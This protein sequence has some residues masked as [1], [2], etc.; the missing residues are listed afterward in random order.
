[1]SVML[2][3]FC[4]FDSYWFNVFDVM[5]RLLIFILCLVKCLEARGGAVDGDT[6]LQAGRSRVRFPKWNMSL[7]WSFRPHYGPGGKG[8]WCAGLTT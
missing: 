1:M 7:M 4:V 5:V 6:A 3:F 2:H 8:G